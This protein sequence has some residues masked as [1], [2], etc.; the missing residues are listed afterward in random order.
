MSKKKETIESLKTLYL[1]GKSESFVERFNAKSP[2][3]QYQS[4]KNWESRMRKKNQKA[5]PMEGIALAVDNLRK[6]ISNASNLSAEDIADLHLLIE[7]LHES[8]DDA[9]KR[10]RNEMLTELMRQQ[11]EISRK[12]SELKD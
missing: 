5:N 10:I 12:I 8:L 4:L 9:K 2:E 11:E 3:K 1:R 7:N 6:S